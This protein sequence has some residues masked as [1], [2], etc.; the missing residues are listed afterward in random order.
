MSTDKESSAAGT[1]NRPPMLVESVYTNHG[2]FVSRAQDISKL[3]ESCYG[4]D[5]QIFTETLQERAMGNVGIGVGEK[6]SKKTLSTFKDKIAVMESKEKGNTMRVGFNSDVRLKD[7]MQQQ[8]SWLLVHPSET[9]GCNHS[10]V[11]HLTDDVDVDIDDNSMPYLQIPTL[12]AK[13]K[14]LQLRDQLQGKDDTNQK[15]ENSDQHHKNVE[16]RIHYSFRI[17]LMIN[18]LTAENAKLKTELSGKMSSGFTASEKPKV[19]AS[20]MYTNSSKFVDIKK[21]SKKLRTSEIQVFQNDLMAEQ[22]L[23]N[24]EGGAAYTSGA[25]SPANDIL[26]YD[27]SGP[28]LNTSSSSS[29]S[30]NQPDL[31]CETQIQS[32]TPT[33][34]QVDSKAADRI[35]EDAAIQ[36]EM[37]KEAAAAQAEETQ[38]AETLS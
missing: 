32:T 8:L 29:L 12:T 5:G 7:L 10:Q 24:G 19:L 18:A 37:S 26:N 13:L 28:T 33:H 30:P 27:T 1:D 6:E 15:V 4:A 23:K 36:A 20:G 21:S 11:E 3:K 16:C 34:G 22:G 35:Q 38:V 9:I 2:N 25:P 31:E 14:M 17:Q